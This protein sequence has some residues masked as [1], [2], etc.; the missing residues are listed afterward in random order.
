MCRRVWLQIPKPGNVRAREPRR[1]PRPT[2]RGRIHTFTAVCALLRQVL[3]VAGTF[4]R[5]TS[6]NVSVRNFPELLKRGGESVISTVPVWST[7]LMSAYGDTFNVNCRAENVRGYAQSLSLKDGVVRTELEW[8]PNGNES[9]AIWL[10]YEVSAHRAIPPLAMVKLDVVARQD[11]K[12]TLSDILDGA[13]S[14]R[15]I[16]LEKNYSSSDGT[17][18]WTGVRPYGLRNVRAYEYSHLEF[19]DTDAVNLTGL[20]PS[21][22]VNNKNPAT[23]S[24]EFDVTLEAGKMFT[25]YKFVGIASSDAY[26][27]PKRVAACT[28]RI[29]ATIGYRLAMADHRLEWHKLWESGDIVFP[30]DVELHPEPSC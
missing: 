13:G 29:G 14:L 10:A 11:T 12:I 26:K 3:D 20:R 27:D 18:M 1:K 2:I 15:T 8:H 23:I 21:G 7:L 22:V 17:G 25:T 16:F 5:Q 9:Q 19:S 24:Q 30:G 4:H 28:A 6:S